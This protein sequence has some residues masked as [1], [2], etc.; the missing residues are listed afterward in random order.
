MSVTKEDRKV[1]VH[2]KW[3]PQV[4]S[5]AAVC[6]FFQ[7]FRNKIKIYSLDIALHTSSLADFILCYTLMLLNISDFRPFTKSKV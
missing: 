6:L 1:N 3:R 4:I 2:L 7:M 5:E